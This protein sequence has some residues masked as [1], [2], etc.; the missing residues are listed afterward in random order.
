MSISPNR[1]KRSFF[2][3]AGL[4]LFVSLGCCIS[5]QVFFGIPDFLHLVAC[6][7]AIFLLYSI[8]ALALRLYLKVLKQKP[9][10]IARFY[11]AY[12]LVKVVASGVI[13]ACG[14][15]LVGKPYSRSF[16][17]LFAIAFFLSLITESYS[18]IQTE[19]KLHK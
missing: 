17:I 14:S 2:A 1:V 15:F 4:S 5:Y 12:Q 10:N 11:M 6:P 18:F 13:A 9:K 19:K 3:S 7:L 16:V 8:S